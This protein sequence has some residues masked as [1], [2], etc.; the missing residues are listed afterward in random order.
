MESGAVG[1]GGRVALV[2]GA[3][4]GIGACICLLLV[5][6]CPGL[7]VLLSARDEDKGRQTISELGSDR[8]VFL[9]M[10]ICDP[11]SIQAAAN[12]VR[13]RFGGLDILVN[14]AGIAVADSKCVRATE[15]ARCIID[16]NYTGTLNVCKAFMPLLRNNARVVFMS[17]NRGALSLLRSETLKVRFNDPSLTFEGVQ[18]LLD[19]YIQAIRTGKEA[20]EGWPAPENEFTSAYGVSKTAMNALC[21]IYA[22]LEGNNKDRKGVLINSCSPRWCRTDMGGPKA[23]RSAEEGAKTPVWLATLPLS[24]VTEEGSS[25]GSALLQGGYF[26]DEEAHE[27]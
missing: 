11:D 27:F 24:A 21:R 1:M 8:I 3:N 6:Q 16:T 2:T 23:T 20:D 15:M 7:T 25:C 18:A 10:D 14:N 9:Q 13:S 26:Y 4:R 17:S 19:Q 5:Q 22:R 12:H